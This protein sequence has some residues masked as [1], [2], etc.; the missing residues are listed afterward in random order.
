MPRLSYSASVDDIE[1]MA[2]ACKTKGNVMKDEGK[3]IDA[4]FFYGMA[5]G[6]DQLLRLGKPE[7]AALR[8]G[9]SWRYMR[10]ELVNGD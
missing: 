5:E 7:D 10:E 1:I 9:F 8:G 4:A 6:I 2:G 3:A